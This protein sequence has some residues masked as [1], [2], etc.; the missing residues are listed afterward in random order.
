MLDDA[1]YWTG[2][3]VLAC[4]ALVMVCV[5]V[6]YTLDLM[7][8]KRRAIYSWNYFSEA[9]RHYREIKPYKGKGDW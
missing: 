2:V 1:I 3:I 9:L 4:G 5:A 8:R 6:G 7:W